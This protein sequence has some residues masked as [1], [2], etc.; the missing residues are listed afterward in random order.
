MFSYKSTR[1]RITCRWLCLTFNTTLEVRTYIFLS[2]QQQATT[3]T[4]TTVK[5]Q[6]HYGGR[7]HIAIIHGLVL[8]DLSITYHR[9]H[10]LCISGAESSPTVHGRN[11][12]NPVSTE[13][14]NLGL[15][16]SSVRGLILQSLCRSGLHELARVSSAL[17][18][19]FCSSSPSYL[20]S[21]FILP[22]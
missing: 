9:P 11:A 14:S 8:M 6:A 12:V 17:R 15:S 5:K 3:P 7:K 22:V 13:C 18:T 1:T 2:N 21:I 10:L 16:L 19:D 4:I 20:D